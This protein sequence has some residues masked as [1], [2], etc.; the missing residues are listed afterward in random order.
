LWF[1]LHLSVSF[2][3]SCLFKI[4]FFK[5]PERKPLSLVHFR[6]W[7]QR[8]SPVLFNVGKLL[9]FQLYLRIFKPVLHHFILE[10]QLFEFGPELRVLSLDFFDLLFLPDQL[11]FHFLK[12]REY[13][14]QDVSNVT[15]VLVH[16]L[17]S[18][19]LV[20]WFIYFFF[21]L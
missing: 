3:H 17:Q 11:L 8:E 1:S 2:T 6:L 10:L 4:F 13:S 9:R 21:R 7:K 12:P 19:Q 16:L 18:H 20:F 14:W 5:Q 15:H